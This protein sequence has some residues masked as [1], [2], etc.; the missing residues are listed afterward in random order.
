MKNTSYILISLFILFLV[1]VV[2]V[3]AQQTVASQKNKICVGTPKTNLDPPETAGEW[4]RNSLVK[5]LSGP[6]AEI[7]PLDAMVAI[8]QQ[9]EAAEKDCGFYL[10]VS[11]MQK[12]KGGG[13]GIGGFL[14]TGA[15]AAP[16]LNDIGSGK[17][18]QTVTSTANR[19]SA[20]LSTAGDLALTIKAKDE[21]TLEYGLINV[22][23]GN[24]AATG[25]IK[26]KAGKDG[27][28][29]LSPMLEQSVNAVLKAALKKQ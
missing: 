16:L 28:D 19:S 24:T 29:I 4:L 13:E 1:S 21:V 12:K 10:V 6:A 5:Y 18:A 11:M 27:E 22:E 15:V 9:A 25:K 20:K 26:A 7:I 17:L 3:D 23:T 8:Q 14:K 2:T